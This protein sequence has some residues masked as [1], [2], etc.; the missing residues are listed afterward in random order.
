M[1]RTVFRYPLV[2]GGTKEIRTPG[3]LSTPI[4]VGYFRGEVCV[5]FD[6][7]PEEDEYLTRTYLVTGTCH[8]IPPDA[9]HIGSVVTPD[10]FAWHVWMLSR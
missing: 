10:E 6:V 4:H 2:I 8:E 3:G 1:K 7:H 9:I 5:W